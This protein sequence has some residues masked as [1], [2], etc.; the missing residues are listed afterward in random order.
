M[1]QVYFHPSQDSKVKSAAEDIAADL[2][3]AKRDRATLKK[4]VSV[5]SSLP[6]I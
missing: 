2:E 1:A 6:L 3:I 4:Y 5:E